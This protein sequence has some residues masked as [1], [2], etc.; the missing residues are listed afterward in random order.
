MLADAAAVMTENRSTLPDLRVD[1][2][3]A[4]RL[5]SLALTVG[6]ELDETEEALRRAWEQLEPKRKE[7][8]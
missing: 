5:A 3:G 1:L 2:E 8:K 6:A 7:T 4:L